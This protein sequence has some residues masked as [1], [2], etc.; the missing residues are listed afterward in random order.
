MLGMFVLLTALNAVLMFVTIIYLLKSN[1]RFTKG[2]MQKI[3]WN[4][5]FGTIFLFGAIVSM[6]IVEFL[7]LQNSILDLIQR[8]FLIF[9]SY[10]FLTAS[11][12]LYK[13]SKVLGFASSDMP[14]KL[15][16]ILKK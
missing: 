12:K 15:K 7:S 3:T 11:Y 4:F 9:S 10:Y 5:S 8:I 16:K 1:I 13:V 14:E 2:E 6:L